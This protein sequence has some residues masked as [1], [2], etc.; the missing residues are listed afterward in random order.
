MSTVYAGRWLRIDLESRQ[1]SEVSIAGEDAQKWL[2]GD[3]MGAHLLYEWLDP[4]LDPLAPASSL[5]IFNGL[6]TGTFAPGAARTSWCGRSPLTGIWGQANMGGRWGAELRF[7]GLDGLVITR[8]APSPVYLWIH[9]VEERVEFRDAS[10]LW[11][12]DTFETHD[13]VR[14]EVDPRAQVAC[15][16]PAG[17]NLVGLAGVMTGG[18]AHNRAAGRSG[19]ER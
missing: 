7:A 3:G 12:R 16:G 6:L 8:R 13:R 14:E 1:V 10:H 11:G 15:I 4:A 17:E 5:V 19:L 9:D 18:Q 2:L